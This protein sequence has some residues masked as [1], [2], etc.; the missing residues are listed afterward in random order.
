M[1]LIVEALTPEFGNRFW[2]FIKDGSYNIKSSIYSERFIYVPQLI[3]YYFVLEKWYQYQKYKIG[4]INM[5][6]RIIL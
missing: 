6:T 4:L 3:I 1:V 2:Q 5:F